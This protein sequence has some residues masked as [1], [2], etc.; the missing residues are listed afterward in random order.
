[1]I[2]KTILLIFLLSSGLL[3]ISERAA[4][5]K[6]GEQKMR[7]RITSENIIIEAT[8]NDSI[9]SQDLAKKLPLTLDMYQHQS[10]EYYANI[11]LKKNEQTQNGYKIGDIAYW[12]NGNSL[13]LFY[14]KGHTEDLIIMGKMTSNIDK[15]HTMEKSFKA[16]IEKIED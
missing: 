11:Y 15:L 16:I 5:A 3:F 10:R 14:D 7:I 9:T 12:K 8:L 1:M 6:A 13:V 2:K 4:T